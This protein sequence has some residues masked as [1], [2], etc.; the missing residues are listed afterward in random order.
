MEYGNSFFSK[1]WFENLNDSTWLP[2]KNYLIQQGWSG[3]E[4]FRNQYSWDLIF[5]IFKN[6]REIRPDPYVADTVKHLIA[7]SASALPGF[8]P[9]T[10]DVAGPIKMLQRVFSDTYHI[11]YDPIIMHTGF[12]NYKNKNSVYYSLDYPIMAQFS[13]RSREKVSKITELYETMSLLNKYIKDVL[14]DKYNLKGTLFYEAVQKTEYHFFHPD[15]FKYSHILPNTKIQE[16][17]EAFK[18][19]SNFP[20]TSSFFSG[21]IRVRSIV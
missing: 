2:F 7:M 6:N 19:A 5:S 20:S 10:N 13:P 9:A 18:S 17:D 1:K 8:V 11:E 21:C 15:Y 12:L 4:F 3:S 16:G 14:S